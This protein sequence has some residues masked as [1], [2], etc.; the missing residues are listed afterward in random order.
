M[1]EIAKERISPGFATVVAVAVAV[2]V[3][4]VEANGFQREVSVGTSAL[5]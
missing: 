4:V 2:A 3:A 5:E 1:T